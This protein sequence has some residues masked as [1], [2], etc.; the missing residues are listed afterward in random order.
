MSCLTILLAGGQGSR[1]H[2]LT[3]TECKP[4]VPFGPRGRIVDFVLSNAAVAGLG[5]ILVATQYRPI[6]LTA[7]LMRNWAPAF[8]GGLMIR[9]G[10]CVAGKQ[11]YRGTADAVAANMAEIDSAGLDHVLVL[12]GDHVF[13]M[14]ISQMMAGH[15][16]S[17][18]VATVAATPVPISEARGFGILDADAQG[19]VT[20]F[21]EKP[22]NPPAMFGDPRRAMASMGIYAFRWDWL[23]AA[24][25]AELQRSG[26]RFDFGHD[27]LPRALR[28]RDLRLHALPDRPDG[29]SGYWRDVGTLDAYR[30]AQLDFVTPTPPI[31][32]PMPQGAR[33]ISVPSMM[34]GF[35]AQAAALNGTVLMPGARLGR[36]AHAKQAILGPDVHLPAGMVVG[37]D[38]NEDR[39]WFRRTDA[40]TVLVTVD[41][42][43]RRADAGT[44]T[45]AISG[46]RN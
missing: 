29:R 25:K 31:P 10:H 15:I 14:D 2:E 38:P 9:D 1:L 7:H 8:E 27:I 21:V 16:S 45:R 46:Y 13:D 37:E 19:Q 41:M 35:A 5:P 20:R 34:S 18:A 33:E 40:G 23:R 22:A 11:G 12:A 42:L 6:T 30:K 28:D 32:L 44:M 43:K 39:R 3:Q 17:G 26:T 24:L 36:G 4:A